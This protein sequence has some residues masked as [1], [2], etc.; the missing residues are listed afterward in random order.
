MNWLRRRL[1]RRPEAV[2]R[3]EIYR[4]RHDMPSSAVRTRTV[5]ADALQHAID[6]FETDYR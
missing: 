1:N 4:L 5:Q 2:L 3:K 6:V